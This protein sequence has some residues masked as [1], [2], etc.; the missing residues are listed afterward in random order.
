M[1]TTTAN[2]ATSASERFA[3]SPTKKDSIVYWTTTAIVATIMLWSAYNFALDAKMKEG[4]SH[5]GLP[6]WFRIELTFTKVLGVMALVIPKTPNRIKEFAYF[7]FGLTLVSATAAH[8]SVGDPIAFEIVH[9]L[10]FVCLVVSY[11]Y[12]HKRVG[13]GAPHDRRR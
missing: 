4:F 3:R 5:L 11:V 9:A 12:H 10:I 7:G 1:T 8:R 6:N 13:E 2:L